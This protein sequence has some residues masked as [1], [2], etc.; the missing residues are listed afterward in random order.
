MRRDKEVSKIS[1]LYIWRIQKMTYANHFSLILV[2]ND[3]RW[4]KGKVWRRINKDLKQEKSSALRV[5]M[6]L[7]S[8]TLT[9][10]LLRETTI[11]RRRT[12]KC[13][14]HF[15]PCFNA[16]VLCRSCKT[17]HVWKVSFYYSCWNLKETGTCRRRVGL[18][19]WTGVC[20]GGVRAH[21]SEAVSVSHWKPSESHSYGVL[22]H[23]SVL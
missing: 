12:T 6:N 18:W 1:L 9:L 16:V 5:R 3:T 17:D 22:V 7:H 19:L 21:V 15:T 10:D 20:E 23:P 2:E 14:C 13:S 4:R 8:D 11:C